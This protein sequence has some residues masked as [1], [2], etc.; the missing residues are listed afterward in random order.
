MKKS[1]VLLGSLI[2]AIAFVASSKPILAQET[3]HIFCFGI[4]K[5]AFS[6]DIVHIEA[7]GNDF[8]MKYKSDITLNASYAYKV[9]PYFNIGGY[10]EYENSTLTDD[11]YGDIKGS[12]VDFGGQWLGEYPSESQFKMQLGGYFGF[13]MLSNEDWDEKPKGMNYGIMAGPC[14]N[15]GKVSIALHVHAGLSN[16]FGD[17][18]ENVNNLVPRVYLKVF[19]NL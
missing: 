17:T 7:G 19:Y 13:S 3:N 16:Y 12:R 14:Y 15:V 1:N 6:D 18:V 4:G 5:A 9:F 11:F 10:F 2:L 8:W